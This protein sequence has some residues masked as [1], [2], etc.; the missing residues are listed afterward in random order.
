[1]I[2]KFVLTLKIS[3]DFSLLLQYEKLKLTLAIENY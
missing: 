3:H 2:P 1:M